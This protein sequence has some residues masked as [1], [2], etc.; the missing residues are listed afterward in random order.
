MEAIGNRILALIA[1]SL[2]LFFVGVQSAAFEISGSKWKGGKTD[3]YVSLTGESP[4]GIAWHD[5]FIAA[6]AD[7]EDDTVFD[8]NVIE[9]A[10]DPCLE[11][12]LNSVDFTDEVC[13][14]EYGANTLAVT[15]RRLSVRCSE[16][17]IF[18]RP[19]S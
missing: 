13:G 18:S 2:A 17:L 9:Q 19:M 16:N 12:G 7:W 10:I 8:F 4:S 6:I 5:S 14:S 3:F 1:V 15:L 11:D